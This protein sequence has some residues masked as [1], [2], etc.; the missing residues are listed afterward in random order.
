MSEYIEL[1]IKA[2]GICIISQITIDV[3]STCGEKALANIVEMTAKIALLILALPLFK[4][5]I[6]I[7]R[8]LLEK[9]NN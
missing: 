5:L 9:V 1:I 2:L 4:N 6:E 8:E 7:I 3:I